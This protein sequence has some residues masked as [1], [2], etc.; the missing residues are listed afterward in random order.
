MTAPKTFRPISSNN[1]LAAAIGKNTVFG[2]LASAVQV[3]TRFVMV[4][5]VIYHLGLGGYGIWSII[6]ATAGYMRFGSAGLKSA[7][8]KYVAE[9]TGNGDFETASKL[10][11]TGSISMLVLS[12]GGLIPIAIYSQKL[13]GASGVPPEFL[14]SA[15]GSIT[16]LAMIMVMANFGAAFEAIVMGA[17]RIDLTRT[18]NI[19]T[20]VG[21]AVGIIALLHFGRGLF[22]MAM[23]MAASELIYVSCCFVASRR[24]VPEIQIKMAY[25]TTSVFRE[26]VRFAGS[27]QLVNVL[28]V[29]YAMLLPV[30]ILKFFGAEI[31]GVYAVATRLVTAVLMGQDALI[32]P[33][34]SGG[35]L[36][37]AT[38]S[39]ER[40]ARF[41]RKSFKI[42]VAVTLVPLAFVGAFGALLAFAWTGQTSPQFGVTIW[43]VCLSSFFNSISRLQL[44]LYRASGNALHDNIRQAF[45]LGVLAVLAV[46]GKAIG[47]HGVL[48]GLAAAELIG[49]IYMFSAMTSVLS[50]F[51]PAKL[52]PDAMRLTAATAATITVGVAAIMLPA[53]WGANGRAVA[54]IK[55]AEV[56]LAC[57]VAVWP[58][59]ALTR[60]I[61]ADE[62]RLV[63]NLLI[64]WRRTAPIGNE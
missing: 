30:T 53:P 29:L 6:M 59:V 34:L 58:A 42:T 62:Q 26:L 13:A 9:A 37:F 63:L 61:S 56:S 32:L 5:I 54:L 8:Q 49:V 60:S 15:A 18:F 46:F 47:F 44:V 4:P 45:R 14:K 28:E 20:T 27:Y 48:L 35:T 22:A 31:A 2:V 64:P 40:L 55:L 12:V 7:F 1:Q 21:E 43:L 52:V 50:F 39:A 17:H 25:F 41:F 19:V 3:G 57:L 11:S 10:L 23:T 51:N 38:G 16:L 24:I 36:V 33:L